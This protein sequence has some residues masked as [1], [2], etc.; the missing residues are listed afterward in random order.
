MGKSS[1]QRLSWNFL[2]QDFNPNILTVTGRPHRPSDQGSVENMN[3]FVKRTLGMVLSKYRLVGKDRNWTEVLGSIASA[4]NSQH[5][6]GKHDVSVY[7]A[8]Y[9][10]KMDHDFSCSKEEAQQCWMVPEHLKV[11]NDPQFAEYACENYIIDD[12]EICNDDEIGND[13]AKGYFS[14]RLLPSDKK[15]EVSD[16]YFFD[17]LQDDITEDYPEEVKRLPTSNAFDAKGK[18]TNVD[19][20]RDVIGLS[21]DEQPK[22]SIY[23]SLANNNVFDNPVCNVLAASDDNGP[24]QRIEIS[25]AD[26]PMNLKKSPPEQMIHQST[27]PNTSLTFDLQ[28]SSPLEESDT[29]SQLDDKYEAHMRALGHPLCNWRFEKCFL[30]NWPVMRCQ[31]TNGC[32]N[33]AHKRCSILWSRTHGRNADS[34]ETIRRFCREHYMYYDKE[35]LPSQTDNGTDCIWAWPNNERDH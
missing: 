24:Q 27:A 2:F 13:D 30:S 5:G 25:T 34:V 17:H 23:E 9:G 26:V 3:K 22:Q 11:T 14:N 12:D 15:E 35:V 18:N 16:E 28:Q 31:F 8:V 1:W 20:V 33:F 32:S 21:K 19:P 7:E 29:E 6:R 10:Q 4:I